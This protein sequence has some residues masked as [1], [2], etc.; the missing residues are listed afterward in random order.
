[1][2]PNPYRQYQAVAIETASP[3]Q[4]VV[5]L[6]DGAVR[7]CVGAEE[8]L[9]QGERETARE[10][11]GRVQAIL[12]ELAGSLNVEAGGELAQNLYRLYEYMNFRLVEASLHWRAEPL[13]E[14]ARLLRELRGAWLEL[15]RRAPAAGAGAGP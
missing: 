14:V 15:V 13:E 1:M 9:R 3:L 6:Y 8:A 2:P 5:M 4:L 11:I 7:F 12:E 10:R